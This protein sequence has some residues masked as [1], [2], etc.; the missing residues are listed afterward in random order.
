MQELLSRSLVDA[1]DRAY[2][3]PGD[4]SWWLGWPPKDDGWFATNVA[5]WESGGRVRAWGLID[6]FEVGEWIDTSG[7]DQEVVWAALDGWLE[8][9]PGARRYVRG[10]DLD[11]LRRLRALGYRRTHDDMVAFSLYLAPFASDP[12]DARVSVVSDPRDIPAR[13][14][15]TRAAFE[16]V[17][18]PL[19]TYIEQYAAFMR[20]PAYPAG[21]DLVA[22]S[23]SGRAAACTIA[24]ADPI[25]GIGNFEPVATHPD[26]HRQGFGT[27]VMREGCRRLAGAGM[28]RALVRTG[29]HNAPAIALYRSIGFTQDHIELALGRL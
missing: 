17:D 21:W 10:D 18:R 15:V 22:W 11:A 28:R 13:A 29:I 24:W 1:P 14:S 19:E 5:I 20:S 8:D 9:R 16:S 26:F 6:G 7:R 3:H 25:S 2:I 23:P 4:L 27:A 12:P